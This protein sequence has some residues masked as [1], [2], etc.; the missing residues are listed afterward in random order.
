M[1]GFKTKGHKGRIC[2]VCHHSMFQH[3]I[4]KIGECLNP[5]CD[6]YDNEFN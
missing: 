4:K 6:T 1:N 2:P 3:P 5:D